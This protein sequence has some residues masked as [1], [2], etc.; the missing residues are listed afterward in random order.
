MSKTKI[1]FISKQSS[2]QNSKVF[3]FYLNYFIKNIYKNINY[4][5]KTKNYTLTQQINN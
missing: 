3:C 1:S 2:I 4:A 5:L